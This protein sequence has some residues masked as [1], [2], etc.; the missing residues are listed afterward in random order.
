MRLPGVQDA[1]D[2]PQ[3]YSASINRGGQRGSLLAAPSAYSVPPVPRPCEVDELQAARTSAARTQKTRMVCPGIRAPPHC[4]AS[5]ARWRQ[6]GHCPAAGTCPLGRHRRPQRRGERA[7]TSSAA[8]EATTSPRGHTEPGDVGSVWR[9]DRGGGRP[10]PLPH[11]TRAQLW[12]GLPVPLSPSTPTRRRRAVAP[13][14]SLP[15]P[16][17]AWPG[18]PR[19]TPSWQ[20]AEDRSGGSRRPAQAEHGPPG[21][22]PS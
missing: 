15:S 11:P 1:A 2:T 9:D 22:V 14:D 19:L 12:A 13:H 16:G 18:P 6:W 7:G 3:R 17:P 4:A 10:A 8:W 5:S 20:P 21:P